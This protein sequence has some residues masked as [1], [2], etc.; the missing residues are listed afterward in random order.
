ME[1]EM[2]SSKQ[3]AFGSTQPRKN[4]P[5]HCAP[6]RLGNEMAPIRGTP[7]LGPGCYDYEEVTNSLSLLHKKPLS[8]KGYSL[9]A[10]TARRF[11][12]DTT[13]QTPSPAEY[14]SFWTKSHKYPPSYAPF[15]INAER[16]PHTMKDD[17]LNPSPG[18]YGHDIEVGRKVSWPGKFGSTDWTALPS[19]ER[20]TF[21]SELATDKE[22]RKH[23][24]RVA[25][26]N[27]YYS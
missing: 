3:L 19:L 24:N 6:D 18:T 15:S 22:F 23:R 21:K 8:K 16:F 12:P 7:N 9:G 27:L 5:H 14:Q 4:F 17:S 20:R 1:H 26:L 10:R 25:Y 13:A 11:P 2:E